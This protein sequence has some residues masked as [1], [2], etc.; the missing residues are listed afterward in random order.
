MTQ[1]WLILREPSLYLYGALCESAP[2][3]KEDQRLVTWGTFYT[4]IRDGMKGEDDRARYGNAP[5]M[6]SGLRCAP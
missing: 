5:A 6:Q 3:L 4:S 1:N 2:F